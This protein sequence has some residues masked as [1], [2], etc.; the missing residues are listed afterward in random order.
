ME[1]N[2]LLHELDRNRGYFPRQ[3]VEEAL[4]RREE[5]TPHLLRS[6][7]EAAEFANPADEAD[8]PFLPIYA[9]FMLAQFREKRAY[10]LVIK[11]CKLPEESLE[12]LIGDTR[13]TLFKP[14]SV[15]EPGPLHAVISAWQ[16]IAAAHHQ[17]ECCAWRS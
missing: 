12:A 4:A 15:L 16:A 7:E 13:A 2:D 17:Q 11:L 14:Q 3:A 9:L 1:L 10:P 8:L 6:L 5:I